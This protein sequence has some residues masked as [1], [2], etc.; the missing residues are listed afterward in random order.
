MNLHYGCGLLSPSGWYNCDASPTLRL[1]RLPVVGAIFRKSLSPLFPPQVHYGD[2]VRG[3]SIPA[4]SC[5]AIY[6][7]HVLEHLSLEDL[8]RALK[9]TYRYLQPG[10]TFRCVV[11]DF[12]QQVA[13]YVSSPDATAAIEFLSYTFLGR[14]TRSRNVLGF[15][16]EYFG[17]SHHL[18]MWDCKAMTHELVAAGFADIRRCHIGDAANIA[19]QDVE[20]A[21]RFKWALAM[22]C[23]K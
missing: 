6:C 13:T 10:G 20:V 22:E 2:I 11:P 5:E 9:A 17:S 1:Q 16:R 18:W 19:F 7:C 12:E 23:K 8:R 15:V 21:S 3:L 14:Q 4:N